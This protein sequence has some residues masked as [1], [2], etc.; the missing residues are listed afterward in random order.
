MLDQIS[1][2]HHAG[3]KEN[4]TGPSDDLASEKATLKNT[5]PGIGTIHAEGRVLTAAR[6]RSNAD[7]ALLGV[8]IAGKLLPRLNSNEVH[9]TFPDWL[10]ETSEQ[11]STEDKVELLAIIK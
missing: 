6:T 3:N 11:M 8:D 2:S 5:I 9:A 10:V 4:T 7:S 1:K